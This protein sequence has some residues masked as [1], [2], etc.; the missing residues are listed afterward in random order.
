MRVR[1]TDPS[2]LPAEQDFTVTVTLG[3]V[4]PNIT[5]AP[6]ESATVGEP[7][8]YAVVATDPTPTRLR[9]SRFLPPPLA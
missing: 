1:V 7:Y 4:A 5:L 8:Q 2:N 6:D 3:N 9:R